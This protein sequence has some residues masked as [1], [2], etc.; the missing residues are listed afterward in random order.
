M[1]VISIRNHKR[2]DDIYDEKLTSRMSL[3]N[4]HRYVLLYG[5][6]AW[7]PTCLGKSQDF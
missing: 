3:E 6:E 1:S 5:C 2:S 4:L 7:S